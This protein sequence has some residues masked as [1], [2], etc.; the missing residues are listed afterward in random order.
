MEAANVSNSN[1]PRASVTLISRVPT[2]QDMHAWI[3]NE[4]FD[5][6]IAQFDF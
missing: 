3:F 4:V 6:Y 1:Y 5:V 2:K